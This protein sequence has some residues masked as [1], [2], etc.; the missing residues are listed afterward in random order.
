[1]NPVQHSRLQQNLLQ[2]LENYEAMCFLFNRFFCPLTANLVESAV[3]HSKCELPQTDSIC[4]SG[5]RK[6]LLT[7]VFIS[8]E[9]LY[10]G[11][12]F[13]TKC[14]QLSLN[15]V[16]DGFLLNMTT[17]PRS[18]R[19]PIQC[20]LETCPSSALFCCHKFLFVSFSSN[21]K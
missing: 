10:H 20:S 5:N 14:A 1:M 9:C 13:G 21:W 2:S 19:I 6:R 8:C 11:L 17:T 15:A 3:R 4:V 7:S 18:S 12:R 16:L